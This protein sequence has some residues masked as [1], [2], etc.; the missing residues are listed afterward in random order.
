MNSGS[1]VTMMWSV[2]QVTFENALSHRGSSS[3]YFMRNF[4]CSLLITPMKGI[5]WL[6][7]VYLLLAQQFPSGAA[8]RNGHSISRSFDM[9]AAQWQPLN[10]AW[11]SMAFP[12][13]RVDN[14]KDVYRIYSLASSIRSHSVYPIVVLA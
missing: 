3:L 5:Q 11:I 9:L 4:V 8:A 7:V 13:N 10:F 14:L 1:H 2:G 6:F 12:L